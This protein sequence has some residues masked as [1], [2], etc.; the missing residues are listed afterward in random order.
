MA[1]VFINFHDSGKILIDRAK[2]LAV[3]RDSG[4]TGQDYYVLPPK[5]TRPVYANDYSGACMV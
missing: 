3:I 1:Y 5:W 4:K 2:I